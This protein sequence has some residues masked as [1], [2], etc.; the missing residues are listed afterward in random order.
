MSRVL[1]VIGGLVSGFLVALALVVAVEF[2]SSVVHPFPPDFA[3]TSAE[4]CRHV[5]R[6]PAWVLAVVVPLW[7]ATALVSTWLAGRIGGRGAALGV[8]VLL[9]A[10]LIWNLSMLPYPVWFEVAC[11]LA[12]AGAVAAGFHM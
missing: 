4:M 1:R 3:G 9:L 6:Y 10:A 5:A 12:I 2:F 8:G 7:A 11:V